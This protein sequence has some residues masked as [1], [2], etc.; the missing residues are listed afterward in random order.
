MFCFKFLSAKIIVDILKILKIQFLSKWGKSRCILFITSEPRR[1][2][3]GWI[4]SCPSW[5]QVTTSLVDT[6]RQ[7]GPD[8]L[9]ASGNS[10][11]DVYRPAFVWFCGTI[12]SPGGVC[13][14]GELFVVIKNH[15]SSWRFPG[16]LMTQNLIRTDGVVSKPFSTTFNFWTRHSHFLLLTNGLSDTTY[17]LGFWD[18]IH[19][20]TKHKSYFLVFQRTSLIYFPFIQRTDRFL[21]FYFDLL[22]I[23]KEFFVARKWK[24]SPMSLQMCL[25][26]EHAEPHLTI[27]C[28]CCCCF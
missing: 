23:N 11:W 5:N 4:S 14:F 6:E 8:S 24:Q 10:Q 26:M 9:E 7:V 18:S 21:R 2:R 12:L 19:N 17:L 27:F 3:D 20:V 16:I 13:G 15:V 22:W 28:C 25:I 1:L